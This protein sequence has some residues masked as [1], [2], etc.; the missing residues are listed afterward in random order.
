MLDVKNN[1]AYIKENT[2]YF[3]GWKLFVN[4]RPNLINFQNIDYPGI[5]TFPIKEGL[6]KVDLRFTDTPVRHYSLI[7]STISLLIISSFMV[8]GPFVARKRASDCQNPR[9]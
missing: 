7:L 5:I 9:V 2:Y 3:P 4:D 8:I 6:H 1:G